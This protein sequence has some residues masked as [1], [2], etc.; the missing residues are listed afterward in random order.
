MS[1]NRSRRIDRDTAEQLLGGAG[2][3]SPAG[4][5]SLTGTDGG[6]GQYDALARLLAAAA[7]PAAEDG[8]LPGEAA[9]L[10]AFR[11]ARPAAPVRP[12]RRRSMSTAALA[13]AFSAKAAAVALAATALGGVAVAAGTGNLPGSLGGRQPDPPAR[14]APGVPSRL[15]ASGQSGPATSADPSGGGGH[16]AFGTPTPT[17]SGSAARPGTGTATASDPADLAAL[18]RGLAERTA[19]GERQRE[20]LADAPFAPLL[21]AAGGPEKVGDYCREALGRK[22]DDERPGATPK[23]S[24]P[25]SGPASTGGSRK[26]EDSGGGAGGQDG[27]KPDS[28]PGADRSARPSATPDRPDETSGKR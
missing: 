23:A 20:L 8:E 18:C 16:K 9:A 19:A 17:A 7:A 27:R 3:G 12:P 10:A 13:Q 1:T 6:S 14:V 22:G 5:A 2:V 26:G 15:G 11:E 24:A 28:R 4:Q 25:S 21:G